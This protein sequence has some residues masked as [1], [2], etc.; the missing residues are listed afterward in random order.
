MC[1]FVLWPFKPRDSEHE[2]TFPFL[3]KLRRDPEFRR[4]PEFIEKG[5]SSQVNNLLGRGPEFARKEEN[6][7]ISV[8]CAASRPFHG[9]L[10]VKA[11]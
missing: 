7:R 11:Y 8:R 4:F 1:G 2:S 9:I 5:R 10:L 3:V 6:S